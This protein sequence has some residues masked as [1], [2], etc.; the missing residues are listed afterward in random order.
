MS[1]LVLVDTD[2]LIDMGRAVPE[3]MHCLQQLEA[4]LTLAISVITQLELWVGCRNT[5]EFRD[6]EHVLTRFQTISL[7]EGISDRTI[8]LFR[9][10]R[11][12]HGLLIP[13]ALIAATALFFDIPLA[14]KNQRD[15][16]FIQHL[17]LL[18]SPSP[19]PPA[20]RR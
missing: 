16:R 17:Q 20:A 11:L 13:D 1:D 12:S 9:H 7:N 15:Y 4:K 2:I 5:Q 18:P 14:S 19:F 8:D 3:A 10:Y 6:V